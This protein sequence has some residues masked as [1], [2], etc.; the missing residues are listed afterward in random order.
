MRDFILDRGVVCAVGGC[1]VGALAASLPAAT[2]LPGVVVGAGMALALM[3]W[4]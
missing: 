1:V 3:V 4:K 2:F